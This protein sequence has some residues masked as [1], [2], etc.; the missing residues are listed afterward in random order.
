MLVIKNYIVKED[1]I[2]A[3]IEENKTKPKKQSAFQRKMQEMME[4]AQE[5][6]KAKQT[7]K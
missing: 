4:Q 5:Q 1:K 3:K 7:K 2:L 6:Q